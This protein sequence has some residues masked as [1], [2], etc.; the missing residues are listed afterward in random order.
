MQIINAKSTTNIMDLRL[1][2][3][4]SSLE[5]PEMASGRPPPSLLKNVCAI[6]PI[7]CRDSWSIPKDSVAEAADILKDHDG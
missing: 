6:E 4:L 3:N 2:E 7:I 1:K 5:V